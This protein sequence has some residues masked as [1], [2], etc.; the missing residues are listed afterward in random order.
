MLRVTSAARA[1]GV[2]RP[3]GRPRGVSVPGV[4]DDA[5]AWQA[6][7]LYD[8]DSVH[9]DDRLGALRYLAARGATLPELRDAIAGDGLP[10]L[11]GSRYQVR[12]RLSPREAAA[13]A[14]MPLD[15]T[16][17]VLR[18]AGLGTLDPDEPQL[19]TSDVH[20]VELAAAATAFFGLEATLQ[21]SRVLGAALAR[22]ADAAMTTF[23]QN[24][25]P[26]L[27]ADNAGELARVEA[28]DGASRLLFDEVP[29][30]I[31]NVFFHACEAAVR[32]TT[33]SGAAATSELTVG[34][35]DLVGSAALGERL[36]AAEL[37]ATIS[38]FER[39]AS[40]R[41][42]VDDGQVI[43]TIG[44][45]VMFVTSDA[46]A[47]CLAALDLADRVDADPI[48]S[49]LRGGLAAGG[50]VRGYGDFYGPVV[51]TA[52]RAVK[53]AVPGE[54]WVTDEVRRRASEAPLV[55]DPLGAQ[56]LRG[57]EHSVELYRVRRG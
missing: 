10:V 40:E 6:A 21:F 46:G 7:G 4:D 36:S 38:A 30:L 54:V 24:V 43:K 1:R 48:L 51:N 32:R 9:A 27:D 5:A 49:Q 55:F 57:F 52:A 42:A 22:V 37:G 3:R 39:D 15:L 41:V 16:L 12:D 34:F 50:L 26:V 45:E 28:N 11:A 31:A 20:T 14:G 29:G 47:A 8:P 13:R 53:L 25:A 18:A 56:T 19:L 33:L 35:V 23:G 44:D 2:W 17:T